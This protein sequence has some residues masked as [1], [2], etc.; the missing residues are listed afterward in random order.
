M[1]K[2]QEGTKHHWDDQLQASEFSIN[3]QVRVLI[4]P[5][6]FHKGHEHQDFTQGL[7]QRFLRFVNTYYQYLKWLYLDP[8]SQLEVNGEQLAFIYDIELKSVVGLDID[9]E[10]KEINL[11]IES[12]ELKNFAIINDNQT[13]IKSSEAD[14]KESL[15]Q[16]MSLIKVLINK[17]L[18]KVK[19]PKFDYFDYEIEIMYQD[20]GIAYGFGI[21]NINLANFIDEFKF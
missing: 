19:L 18:P 14:I 15:M 9:Q 10:Q 11:K 13:G 17:Y 7:N 2:L 16:V 8:N 5:I 3:G 12:L 20:G 21:S 1:F 4:D 6:D